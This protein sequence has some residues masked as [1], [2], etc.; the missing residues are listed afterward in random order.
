[1]LETQTSDEVNSDAKTLATWALESQPRLGRT[2]KARQLDNHR[3]WFL[4]NDGTLTGGRGFTK[5]ELAG[6][7][8]WLVNGVD[9]KRIK[10]STSQGDWLLSITRVDVSEYIVDIRG[11]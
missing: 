10:L 7:F 9:Q 1:M 6:E 3:A 11:C 8:E 2:I 5:R 4:D